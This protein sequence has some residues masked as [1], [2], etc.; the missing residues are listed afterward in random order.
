MLGYIRLC[1]IGMIDCVKF[2]YDFVGLIGDYRGRSYGNSYF[3]V[4]ATLHRCYV[5]CFSV[6]ILRVA[7]QGNVSG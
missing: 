5:C 7:I 4:G 3:R 6:K 2:A 1:Y